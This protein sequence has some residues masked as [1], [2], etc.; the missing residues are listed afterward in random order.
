[1]IIPCTRGSYCGLRCSEPK[2]PF[3]TFCQQF[4]I[5]PI[6]SS[7]WLPLWCQNWH[8]LLQLSWFLFFSV[9]YDRVQTSKYCYLS[10]MLLVF[11]TTVSFLFLGINSES[12][13][14]NKQAFFITGTLWKDIFFLYPEIVTNNGIYFSLL[15]C[16]ICVRDFKLWPNHIFI[17]QAPEQVDLSLVAGLENST[18]L[19]CVHIIKY[20]LK[21]RL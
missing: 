7:I 9:V 5:V 11:L 15:I 18:H 2:A 8:H 20:Y 14:W 21:A 12:H 1:M 10:A 17:W 19:N 4:P 16:K 6:S 3:K 13:W